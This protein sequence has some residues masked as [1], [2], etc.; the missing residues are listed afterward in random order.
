MSLSPEFTYRLTDQQGLR[1]LLVEG[2]RL[3]ASE[4]HIAASD[5]T[6]EQWY[7]TRTNGHLAEPVP[8]KGS[9]PQMM[10]E[11]LALTPVELS[12]P[13]EVFLHV[14]GTPPPKDIEP[15]LVAVEETYD[16]I[17]TR[18]MLLYTLTRDDDNGATAAVI[19]TRISTR[20][21][22]RA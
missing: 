5:D 17:V 3:D 16:K 2:D 10:T 22:D 12:T 14:L 21:Q 15:V 6:G 13:D 20:E 18:W 8:F 1:A 11:V 4:M 19:A 7:R 9:L